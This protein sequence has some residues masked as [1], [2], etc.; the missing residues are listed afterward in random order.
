MASKGIVLAG[1]TGSRLSP[2]TDSVSK[3]LLPVYDKPMIY[4]PLSLLMGA[5]I[6]ELLIITTPHD[7]ELFK[8]LLGDGSRYGC[9]FSYA[10][11]PNPG[12]LAQAFI[13]GNSFIG[14]DAVALVLGDNIFYGNTLQQVIGQALLPTG[15]H[16]FAYHVSDPSRYG[17][18][19]FDKEGRAESIEEKPQ[20]P[21]SNYAVTGLYFFDNQVAQIADSL[22]PSS[23]GE[24]EITD[25]IRH[26][27]DQ[28]QLTVHTLN[29]GT[30]WLDT[31]T[32]DSLMQAGQF[33][34][35]IEKRQ[36]LKIGCI[37]EAAYSQGFIDEEELIA[38]AR[39][40]MASGYGQY[41]MSLIP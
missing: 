36:G 8:Q 6:R 30:A 11:Q 1:G 21:K 18:V 32:F 17:V 26:Y 38:L 7:V 22:K 5:G 2:I 24:L 25:V 35:L 29:K 40:L 9:A 31:G 33:V 37:E 14:D 41:L 23:R 4:Y 27:L 19:S 28:G 10:V 15:G 13:I 39:P 34:Q 3:Q 12:G 16:V 20:H